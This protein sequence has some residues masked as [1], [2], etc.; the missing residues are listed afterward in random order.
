MIGGVRVAPGI[1]CRTNS[2]QFSLWKKQNPPPYKA[3]PL[4]GAVGR[5]SPPDSGEPV[6]PIT[7]NKKSKKR[8]I[9]LSAIQ[10]NQFYEEHEEDD[11]K[12]ATEEHYR[13]DVRGNLR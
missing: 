4:K 12:P 13:E 3:H 11:H 7:N 8:E 1:S 5:Q 6:K 10:R 9:L 2:R